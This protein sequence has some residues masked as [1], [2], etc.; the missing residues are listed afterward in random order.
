MNIFACNWHLDKR[1]D[2]LPL[3][4][5]C[6]RGIGA[7]RKWGHRDQHYYSCRVSWDQDIAKRR[8]RMQSK[9]RQSV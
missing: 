6:R 1:V 7:D 5:P 4:N 3:A 2:N 9:R 8:E